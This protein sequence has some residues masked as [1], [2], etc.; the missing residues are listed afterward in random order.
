VEISK[1]TRLII[2]LK[3]IEFYL[4]K[5]KKGEYTTQML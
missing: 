3:D 4:R 5:I 1:K 2:A